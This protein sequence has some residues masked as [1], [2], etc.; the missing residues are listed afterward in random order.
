MNE[1]LFSKGDPA[2]NAHHY[3]IIKNNT[4]KRH[5]TYTIQVKP[6]HVRNIQNDRYTGEH[7]YNK[8][9]TVNNSITVRISTHII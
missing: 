7:D 6:N 9:Q 3:H 5:I 1:D 8:A 4:T 2:I